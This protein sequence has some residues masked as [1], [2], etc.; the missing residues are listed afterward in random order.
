MELQL[1][2]RLEFRDDEEE[3]VNKYF[4]PAKLKT[5]TV[6]NKYILL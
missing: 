3:I 5:Q 1:P 2:L 6:I 4:K